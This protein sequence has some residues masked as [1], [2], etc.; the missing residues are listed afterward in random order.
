V[1]RK[2]DEWMP[3]HIGAY[4]ADTT[5][6][7][8]DQHGA[9]ILLLMAYWRRG[10]PL[11]A[12][13]GRLA[14]IAKATPAE[15][16]KIRPA[17]VEFFTEQDGAWHQKRADEELSKAKRMTE[18]KAEAGSLGGKAK[19]SHPADRNAEHAATRSQRLAE[20]RSKGTHTPEEWAA[21]VEVFSGKCVR[22]G[23]A[24]DKPFKDHILPIYK[25]GSDALENLQPLCPSCNSAKGPEEID[26][27]QNALPDWRER[28]AKCL[29]DAK[30]TPA[31]QPQPIPTPDQK[32]ISSFVVG[33]GKRGGDSV[34]IEDPN[35][36]IARFQKT[37]AQALGKNGWTIV[38]AAADP[39]SPDYEQALQACKS[40]AQRIGKGWPR[41]WPAPQHSHAAGR[42]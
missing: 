27:R 17:M 26:H 15:W 42:A 24:P 18:A 23:T 10:G 41:L 21:L 2:P 36:R 12:D 16:R 35:E 38:A 30:Q 31:P 32:N 14:A 5:H 29:A 40:A 39:T 37:I 4:H 8:R 28:L 34:T 7:T 33:R 11:P 6:L 1:T 3:L 19:W 22:C 13:D 9:Y 25:G 20:A